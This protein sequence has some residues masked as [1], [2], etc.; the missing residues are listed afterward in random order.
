MLRNP[1][2][3]IFDEAMSSIDVVTEALLKRAMRRLLRGRTGIIIAH[4]LSTIMDCDRIIVLEDG[5]II[6]EGR[7]HE[8]LKVK[9]KYYEL[10]ESMIRAFT[11]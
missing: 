1:A 8:L 11:S 4:R 9:G 2:I 3:V 7:H 10:Y 6:E 5:K